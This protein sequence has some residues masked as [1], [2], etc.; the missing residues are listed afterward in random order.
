MNSH[1]FKIIHLVEAGSVIGNETAGS[2]TGAKA[3]TGT[4]TEAGARSG[5]GAYIAAGAG[6]GASQL[7]CFKYWNR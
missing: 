3:G 4:C 1:S 5:T 6:A 7:C 2:G